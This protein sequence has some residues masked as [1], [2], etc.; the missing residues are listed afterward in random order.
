MKKL[1]SIFLLSS[2]LCLASELYTSTYMLNSGIPYHHIDTGIKNSVDADTLMKNKR[3]F[4]A[5]LYFDAYGLTDDS[6]KELDKL[7]GMIKDNKKKTYYVSIVGHTSGFIDAEH[8]IE[9]N[10]WSS[11]W[12]NMKF[13]TVSTKTIAQRVN[14][15]IADIYNILKQNDIGADRIYTEN[16]MDRDPISTEATKYGKSLNRRVAIA[17]YY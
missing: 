16:R 6:K 5:S 4:W 7:I 13:R 14:K 10:M 2:A 12:H 9:L 8:S 3:V 17:L 11:F 1:I 15:Q